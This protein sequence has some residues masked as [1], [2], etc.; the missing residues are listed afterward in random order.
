[1][2]IYVSTNFEDTHEIYNI[3]KCSLCHS[4]VMFAMNMSVLVQL[5]SLCSMF[6]A[7]Q[8]VYIRDF[9]ITFST[10]GEMQLHGFYRDS[11][12]PRNILPLSLRVPSI[13]FK[14]KKSINLTFAI[15]IF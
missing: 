13:L 9:F 10:R 11:V 1:M 14:A 15:H 4:L 3:S 5:P 6:A 2:R 12:S 7:I 8:V